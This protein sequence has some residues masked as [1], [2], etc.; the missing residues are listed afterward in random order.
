M[1]VT[2][3]RIGQISY[4]FDDSRTLQML[5]AR[6]STFSDRFH[7]VS[8]TMQ[9]HDHYWSLPLMYIEDKKTLSI[10]E[11]ISFWR[12][13]HCSC[14]NSNGILVPHQKIKGVGNTC[15]IWQDNFSQRSVQL[16]SRN[17]VITFGPVYHVVSWVIGDRTA[18]LQAIDWQPW[19]CDIVQRKTRRQVPG[20]NTPFFQ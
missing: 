14:L 11:F 13:W 12:N 8:F 20:K 19:E 2:L 18:T 1:L 3:R 4:H 6:W 15:L 16:S 5:D 9:S 7:N 17:G 10:I